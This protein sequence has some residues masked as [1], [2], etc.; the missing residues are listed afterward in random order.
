M[1]MVMK[2][3]ILIHT[4]Q[5]KEIAASVLASLIKSKNN[6]NIKNEN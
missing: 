2:M 6:Y 3:K 5:D 4:M 1:K